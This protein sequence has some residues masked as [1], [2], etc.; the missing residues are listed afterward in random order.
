MTLLPADTYVVLNKGILNN[1]DKNNLITL[2]EPIIGAVATSLYL[3]L[4]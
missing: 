3:T 1:E 2:Y 4:W